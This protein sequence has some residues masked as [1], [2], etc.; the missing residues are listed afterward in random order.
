MVEVGRAGGDASAGASLSTWLAAGE[1]ALSGGLRAPIG[2]PRGMVDIS[3][4]S[5]AA[6]SAAAPLR[7]DGG[8]SG[9]GRGGIMSVPP[10]ASSPSCCAP[11]GKPCVCVGE[12]GGWNSGPTDAGGGDVRGVAGFGASDDRRGDAAGVGRGTVGGP[13]GLGA[14]EPN[15][16]ASASA[17]AS[18]AGKGADGRGP[19]RGAG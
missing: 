3:G 4:L 5:I 14:S 18:G 9:T 6:A 13:L 8:G 17:S 11:F 1:T 12:D 16:L 15:A 10:G 7:D 19:M 2:V